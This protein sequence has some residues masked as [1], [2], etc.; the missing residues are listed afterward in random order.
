M[1]KIL[2]KIANDKKLSALVVLGGLTLSAVSNIALVIGVYRLS[3]RI[4]WNEK[5]RS[6]S[7]DR[8]GG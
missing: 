5:K 8:G 3:F 6:R 2:S 4:S 1:N 7:Y